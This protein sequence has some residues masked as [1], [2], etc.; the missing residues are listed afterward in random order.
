MIV[1]TACAADIPAWKDLAR[2]VE[3]FFGASMADDPHFQQVL[4]RKVDQG[5]AFCVREHDGEPGTPLCG[6][7][8]FSTHHH[9]L[10]K[11]GWLA[12][13]EKWRRSGVARVLVMH[14][15]GL[16]IPPAEVIVTT[17]QASDPDAEPAWRFYL[18]LGFEPAELLPGDGPNG[19]TRQRFRK[20]ITA[21]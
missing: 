8:L 14:A 21:S 6:G 18:S 19:E 12:V 10:Y 17:F 15:L 16:V 20:M 1:F 5:V 2:E 11:I 9:P 7:L 13:S 4:Q 3:P